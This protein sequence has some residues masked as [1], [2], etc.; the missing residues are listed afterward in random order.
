MVNIE[1]SRYDMYT[2]AMSCLFDMINDS[3]IEASKSLAE[4]IVT[5]FSSEDGMRLS[6]R[7][8]ST[9]FL[10]NSYMEIIEDLI[11]RKV[12]FIVTIKNNDEIFAA[13][14]GKDCIY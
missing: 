1:V 3:D 7:A 13:I 9:A 14:N 2:S 10:L 4:E 5:A 11:D 6:L 12:P 8:G